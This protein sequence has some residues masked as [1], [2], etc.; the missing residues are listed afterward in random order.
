MAGGTVLVVDDEEKM[1]E[2]LQLVLGQDGHRVVLASSGERALE[3]IRSE[4]DIDVI[5]TDLMMPGIGGME[6]LEEARR[7]LPDTPVVVITGY[8]T[9]QNAVEAM[10][11]GAF[12]YL[13]KPFKVDEVRLVVRKALERRE[14]ALE[15]RRLRR[16]LQSIRER[17]ADIVGASGKMQAVFR[18]VEKVAKTDATVLIRGESGTGKDLIAR[19]IHRQSLRAAK[20]FISI[21][22]AALPE[23]LLESELFGHARGAFTGAVSTKRGLF[24]EAEGGTVFLDEIGDVSLALQAKLLRFLQSREFIRVGETSV[25]RVDVR[26]V[27]ATNKDLEDAIERGDFRRDLYYRLNVI[28]VHLPPLRE[29]RED[30]PLLAKHFARKYAASLLKGAMSFSPEAMAALSSYDWPGNVRELENAVE[31]AVVLAEG[32]EL[33][34]DDFPEEIARKGTGRGMQNASEGAAG[35]AAVDAAGG[36]MEFDEAV[37]SYKRELISR[38]LERA[39]GVQARAAE[40]LG[41]KRTTLN[42]MMKRLGMT[43]RAARRRAGA[44]NLD[45]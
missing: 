22:C 34:L 9:V 38:A 16:E 43:G 27:V 31:R 14:I 13:P 40:I 11:A 44:K 32:N 3:E 18:L 35:G 24:E 12:D 21:N 5:V 36:E 25:R 17:S 20:P 45:A 41:I 29:R 10:K 28:T 8:S 1:C 4:D 19:E 6:V 2:F 37:D 39:G 23:T 30:I 26:V 42:E 15:N 33:S 7:S